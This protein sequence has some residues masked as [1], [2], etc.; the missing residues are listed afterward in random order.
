[1]DNLYNQNLEIP[2]DSKLSSY[3]IVDSDLRYL[4]TMEEK[5]YC[6]FYVDSGVLGELISET[7][8][9]YEFDCF[10]ITNHIPILSAVC[11][12][13]KDIR[14]VTIKTQ[15]GNFKHKKS[16]KSQDDNVLSRYI[17][18]NKTKLF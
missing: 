12:I 3:Y 15:S 18:K 14:Y 6:L 16:R 13:K 9:E 7:S 11:E 8:N 5:S 4:S 17:N 10:V 1:M 2:P